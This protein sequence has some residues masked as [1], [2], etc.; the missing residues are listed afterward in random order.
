MRGASRLP[1]ALLYVFIISIFHRIVNGRK[2]D[3][4]N[5][6]AACRY[7]FP[8]EPLRRLQRSTPQSAA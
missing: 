8:E 6:A 2:M 5:A 7:S 3:F 1:A 4:L